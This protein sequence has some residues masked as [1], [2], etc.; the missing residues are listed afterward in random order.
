MIEDV[1]GYLIRERVVVITL[2]FC[3]INEEISFRLKRQGEVQMG[4]RP[5]DLLWHLLFPNQTAP[6]ANTQLSFCHVLS[7]A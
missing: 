4:A 6:L 2:N 1:V 3:A 7:T 5:L